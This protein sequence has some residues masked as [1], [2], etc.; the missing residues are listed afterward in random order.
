MFE[1][2]KP[3]PNSLVNVR[4]IVCTFDY[5]IPFQYTIPTVKNQLR[6]KKRAGWVGADPF[7]RGGIIRNSF[8]S[9]NESR[10]PNFSFNT[11][12]ITADYCGPTSSV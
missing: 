1:T 7:L 11:V 5:L 2:E 8:V 4:D 6:K 10:V 3:L 12:I 9:V